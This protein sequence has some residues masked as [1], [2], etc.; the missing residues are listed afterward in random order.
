MVGGIGMGDSSGG[1][2]AVDIAGM[3]SG[4][5]HQLLLQDLLNCFR[6]ASL[7]T[8]GGHDSALGVC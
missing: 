4:S 3:S 6:P 7:D 2:T 1:K 5:T 8:L